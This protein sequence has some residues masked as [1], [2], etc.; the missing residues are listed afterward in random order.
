MGAER[1][2]YALVVT[3]WADV[4]GGRRSPSSAAL[5][6]QRGNLVGSCPRSLARASTSR[7]RKGIGLRNSSVCRRSLPCPEVREKVS[8]SIGPYGASRSSPNVRQP[9]RRSR[10][11]GPLAASAPR[12]RVAGPAACCA[13]AKSTSAREAGSGVCRS[14]RRR[15]AS[16]SRPIRSTWTPRVPRGIRPTV[17]L[18]TLTMR[19]A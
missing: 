2:L 4:V 14:L 19:T 6:G 1:R 16:S 15:D 11:P 8:R 5:C 3:S 9:L 10:R 12:R 18:E 13:C 17:C 7:V